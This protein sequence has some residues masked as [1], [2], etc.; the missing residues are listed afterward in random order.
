M[1]EIKVKSLTNFSTVKEIICERALDVFDEY[2]TSM[3]HI[4]RL[5]EIFIL[6]IFRIS[7]CTRYGT[8][9]DDE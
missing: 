9:A 4:Y 8:F 7:K 1:D 6:F 5:C 3:V 2:H